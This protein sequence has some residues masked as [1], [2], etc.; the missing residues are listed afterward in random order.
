MQAADPTSLHA[1]SKIRKIELRLLQVDLSYQREPSRNLVLK[2]IEDWD[3][4][5]SEL[6]LVSDRGVRPEDG[7]V[8]GGL[9]IINGQHRTLAARELKLKTMDARVIDLSQHPDPAAVEA[10]LRLRTNVRLGDRSLER[11]KAQLR[12]G[13]EESIAIQKLLGRYKTQINFV[14]NNDVGV[15]CVSAI[16]SLW[17]WDDGVLLQEVVEVIVAAYGKMAGKSA[18]A[19]LV[20]AI[21]WTLHAHAGVLDVQRLINK[22]EGIVPA[23]LEAKGKINASVMGKPLW[24]NIYRAILE[25]YN[26][27]LTPTNKLEVIVKGSTKFGGRL[28]P[29]G[30][31]TRETGTFT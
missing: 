11:F 25:E 20:R 26:E 8:V 19:H 23:G 4:V 17:R 16:E 13:D 30:S 5:A 15:N 7:T 18:T 27:K 10:V 21:G 1:N 24:F 22:L 12:A 9:F 2:L 29:S 14:P 28:N 6:I 31:H 3:E